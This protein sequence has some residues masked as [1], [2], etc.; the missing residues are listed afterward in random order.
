[1]TDKQTIYLIDGTAYIHRAFH[2]IRG[3]SNSTGLPTNAAYGFARMLIKL[4][5][6]REPVYAA[7]FF[8][9]KA[10][11]FRHEIYADYKANRPPMA[12][13]MAVQIPYIK[14]ITEGFNIPII[15]QEGYEAD[16]LI[17]T[18]ARIA[19]EG[20]FFVIMV[21]GDKDFVQ[22]ITDN[23]IIWDPMKDIHIDRESVRET[24]GIEPPQMVDVLGLAGDS[25]DN[26]PGVPG[27]GQKTALNLLK[28]YTD[29]ADLYKRIDGLKSPKQREKLL[30][31]K[32]QAF[33]SRDLA[34]IRTDARISYDLEAFKRRPEDPQK[35]G[36]LFQELE[37]RQ[38]QKDYP[39]EAEEKAHVYQAIR[40]E[41]ALADLIAALKA[42]EIFAIDTETTDLNPM[43]AE[44]V[45]ISLALEPHQAFYIPCAHVGEGAAHQMDRQTVLERLRP[46]LEDETIHKIGQNIKYD[47]MV[48]RRCG[49]DLAGV[50]FD[51][52]VASYLINPGKR[53]HNLDQIALDYLGHKMIS[54]QETVREGDHTLDCFDQV[55]I[56]KATEY[57]GED[58][59]ITFQAYGIFRPMLADAGLMPLFEKVEM[60]LIR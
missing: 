25:S 45:G 46:V 29:M 4:I 27:V 57:A 17:G 39:A 18:Y 23:C 26:I 31:H 3:L 48:F 34:A 58:A 60:P 20:G 50:V 38:L 12:E 33:L 6:D 40:D 15:E 22:L 19:E 47:W 5:H 21:T 14:A 13:E 53:V 59:D 37:F 9:S 44:L 51:T 49:L 55:A 16:D 32:D 41:A 30:A 54:Y 24:Y 7:M 56:E 2:A 10:P 43:A 52:M 8:D 42:S 1:M 11:T 35:L 28:T 36:R